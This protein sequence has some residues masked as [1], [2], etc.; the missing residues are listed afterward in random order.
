MRFKRDSKQIAQS[1]STDKYQSPVYFKRKPYWHRTSRRRWVGL[2][3]AGTVWVILSFFGASRFIPG[4]SQIEDRIFMNGPLAT[5][6]ATLSQDCTACHSSWFSHVKDADCMECHAATVAVDENKAAVHHPHPTHAMAKCSHCHIEHQGNI[7]FEDMNDAF[8]TECHRTLPPDS[9][10]MATAFTANPDD[11]PEIRFLRDGGS[12]P[13]RL[14]FNHKMHLA[15]EGVLTGEEGDPSAKRVMECKDCHT[16]DARGEYFEE[17]DY[18]KHC[19]TCHAHRVYTFADG[20]EIPHDSPQGV[21]EFL[22]RHFYTQPDDAQPP[23]QRR[24]R[25]VDRDEEAF[26]KSVR[27]RVNE[28]ERILYRI[29]TEERCVQCH[30]I[31]GLGEVEIDQLG[32][33]PT[34]EV[35]NV[36]TRWMPNG[37]FD[38]SAHGTLKCIECHP[39]VG[40]SEKA[41]DLIF[42][43]SIQSCAACHAPERDRNNCTLCHDF[44]P[45]GVQSGEL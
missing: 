4:V 14:K 23:A 19:G 41:S 34:V 40:E 33:L 3:A 11:H 21:R 9:G 12:D 43:D 32:P 39:G 30:H 16:L 42:F 10:A 26:E 29:G 36:P 24:I 18:A 31:S 35:P 17:I 15:P 5:Y 44:H 25:Y 37:R 27:S 45:K 2:T 8:C 7:P 20:E 1:V 28:I 6:H 38:H 13:G 22:L